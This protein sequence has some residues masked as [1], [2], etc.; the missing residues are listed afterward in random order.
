[1]T[2]RTVG[3]LESRT[4]IKRPA[5]PLWQN[6][7]VILLTLTYL[8]CELAFNSRLLDLVGGISTIDD[9]HHMERYGRALTAFAAA[10]LVFQLVLAGNA[11]LKKNGYCFPKTYVVSMLF[12][13]CLLS[14]VVTWH[15][16]EWV[17]E[18]QVEK[19][20]GEFRQKSL[21]AQLFQQS[22]M[23]GH[24][25]LEG[26]PIDEEGGQKQTWT[27]P[28]G[29]AFLAMLPMLLSSVSRYHDLLEREAAANLSDSISAQEGGVLGYYKRWLAARG[30][31]YKDYLVYY[32][33]EQALS[34]TNVQYKGV[35]I[36]GR[37]DWDA[38][39]MLDVVQ[40]A[41]RTELALPKSSQIR[42]EYP[43]N[44]ALKGF[45]LELQR[46][47]LDYVVQQ[48]LP[49]LQADLASYSAGGANEKQGEDAARAV[50]V[51][52]I[53]LMFS[54]LGALTHLAKLLYLLLVPLTAALLHITS[55]RPVRLLNRH[56][57][58]FPVMMICLLL[59][60]FSVMNNSI[61]ASPAYHALRNAL[62]GAEV[63]ITDK[64]LAVSGGTLLRVIHAVSVGQS[65]SYPLNHALRQNVLSGFDFGYETRDD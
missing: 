39:F 29:K 26:V 59:G 46:P 17:I 45:A 23:R 19:S 2:E 3:E 44:D 27:S 1:M 30:E 61:T 53:A 24:Q 5:L 8:I 25:T 6:S 55:W 14:G 31:I 10:L 62:Q 32:N 21:L 16:V 13:L 20:T 35:I 48:Q 15:T 37:L 58:I 33:N 60:M 36:P 43:K 4:D 9:I 28:S 38:F 18:S 47:H 41:L 50:I 56:P 52:P 34:E 40:N 65:Y 54:L 51:P 22:L 42:P 64:P 63:A 12:S 7:L 11:R 49:R 57:L